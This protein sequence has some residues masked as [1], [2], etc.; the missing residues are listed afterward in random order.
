MCIAACQRMQPAPSCLPHLGIDS[1]HRPWPVHAASMSDSRPLHRLT[2]PSLPPHAFLKTRLR[3]RDVHLNVL[4]LT[5]LPTSTF[6]LTISSGQN[7]DTRFQYPPPPTFRD[8]NTPPPPPPPP[9]FNFVTG[10][11]ITNNCWFIESS[12]EVPP[13]HPPVISF[14]FY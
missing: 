13:P 7:P 3:E 4:E 14:Q 9:A 5:P 10:G 6:L 8:S 11:I 1:R 2:P 12:W